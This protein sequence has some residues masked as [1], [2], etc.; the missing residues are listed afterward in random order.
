MKTLLLTLTALLT[1]LTMS[2]QV[3][4][5]TELNL[6]SESDHSLCV[7]VDLQNTQGVAMRIEGQNVRIYYDSEKLEFSNVFMD[8]MMTTADYEYELVMD[9]AGLSKDMVDQLAFDDHMGFLNF[10]ITARD[11]V[12]NQSI[13]ESDLAFHAQTVCFAKKTDDIEDADIVLARDGFTDGYSKAFAVVEA[14]PVNEEIL[15]PVNLM[16][17]EQTRALAGLDD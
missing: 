10:A 6:T 7:S 3:N 15:S 9:K 1:T 14:S 2:A 5:G 16:H 17:V 12:E 11:E 13:I 8:G 4:I